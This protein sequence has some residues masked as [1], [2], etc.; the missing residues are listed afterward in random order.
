[1]AGGLRVSDDGNGAFLNTS[2]WTFVNSARV[3]FRDLQAGILLLEVLEPHEFNL[4]T[5]GAI[6]EFGSGSAWLWRLFVES[7]GCDWRAAM[8]IPPGS[9]G[10]AKM[11]RKGQ[12]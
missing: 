4:K 12:L 1:V 5:A 6:M 3:L 8:P 9:S 10:A 2:V 7:R 11:C